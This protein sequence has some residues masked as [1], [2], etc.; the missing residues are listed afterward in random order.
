MAIFINERSALMS[1]KV[2]EMFQLVDMLP[3]TEQNFVSEMI[4]RVVLAWDPD[5]T[6]VTELERKQ[7]ESAQADLEQGE[8]VLHEDVW[9]FLTEEPNSE[10]S[11]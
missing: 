3:E 2:R 8:Y 4:K 5:F 9:N 11:D 10:R 1:E 6:K 7:M